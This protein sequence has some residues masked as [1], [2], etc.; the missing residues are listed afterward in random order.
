MAGKQ[1][2]VERDARS[3]RF[4]PTGTEEQRPTWTVRQPVPV[5][6]RRAPTKQAVPAP[7]PPGGSG[8]AGGERG[9]RADPRGG[10]GTVVSAQTASAGPAQA[11]IAPWLVVRDGAAA[12]A[13]YPA[14][15]GATE[16]YRL[17]GGGGG[18]VVAQL[19]VGGAELWLQE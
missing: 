1:R 8:A 15:F 4:V 5:P 16:R 18:V 10:R 12:V 2:A 9:R 14:A 3:G 17:A 13:F 11:R 6:K 19:A 7:A